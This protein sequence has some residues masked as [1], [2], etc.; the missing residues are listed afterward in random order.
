MPQHAPP[1]PPQRGNGAANE[2]EH[3]AAAHHAIERIARGTRQAVARQHGQRFL[4]HLR[5]AHGVAQ[6]I[7]RVRMRKRTAGRCLP[8]HQLHIAIHRD[9]L[10]RQAGRAAL[11]IEAQLR[12]LGLKAEHIGFYLRLHADM[13][14]QARHFL[15][16]KARHIRPGD[17]HLLGI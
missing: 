14:I 13:P 10:H 16:Q 11:H 9:Q 12:R 8:R 7:F 2:V 4:L 1:L 6:N 17:H 3:R 5:I 15:A